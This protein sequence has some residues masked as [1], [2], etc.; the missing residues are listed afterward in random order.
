MQSYKAGQSHPPRPKK[1]NPALFPNSFPKMNVPAKNH[2]MIYIPQ[3][4]ESI[5][6]T[7]RG[8]MSVLPITERPRPATL[9]SLL[10]RQVPGLPLPQT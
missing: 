6:N 5:I 10:L 9:Q 2:E 8:T 3:R 7:H 1:D 4:H